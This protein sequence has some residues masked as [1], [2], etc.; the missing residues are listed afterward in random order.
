MVD[1]F[2]CG[3]KGHISSECRVP[4]KQKGGGHPQQKS[5][6]KQPQG[7][8]KKFT[9]GGMRQ[10]I[11]ALIDKNF[12]EGNDDYEEFIREVEEQGF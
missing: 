8:K 5:K 4:P 6:G 2:D 11:H 7:Q 12:Q 10:H 3:K 1:C 9:P